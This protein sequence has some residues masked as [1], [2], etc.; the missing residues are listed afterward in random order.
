M[1]LGI[2]PP[3]FFTSPHK[4]HPQLSS[5]TSV[6]TKMHS[7]F[8]QQEDKVILVLTLLNPNIVRLLSGHLYI[9]FPKI[10]SQIEDTHKYLQVNELPNLI[11]RIF[12]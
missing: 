2:L 10:A 3:L 12:P 9:P 11:L 8:N 1:Y 4:D 5:F 7:N 6:D